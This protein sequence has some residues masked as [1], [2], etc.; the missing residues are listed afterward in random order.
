VAAT[1]AVEIAQAR[2][3]EVLANRK[4]AHDLWLALE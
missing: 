4:R 3:A 1:N 2:K